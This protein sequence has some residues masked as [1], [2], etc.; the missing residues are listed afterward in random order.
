MQVRVVWGSS[1]DKQYLNNNNNSTTTGYTVIAIATMQNKRMFS[2]RSALIALVV[3][4]LHLTHGA[5]PSSGSN[6][7][8]V[9]AAVEGLGVP[10][11]PAKGEFI[12]K[13]RLSQAMSSSSHIPHHQMPREGGGVGSHSVVDSWNSPD[14][15]LSLGW[16]LIVDRCLAHT[17]K[18]T[19]LTMDGC[20]F[21]DTSRRH[22][23][24]C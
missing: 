2:W 11:S 14:S 4:F 19:V 16:P 12:D 21:E 13:Y 20:A 17:Q 10:K 22:I 15:R 3:V 18:D 9:L 5:P 7:S 1:P 24:S 6:C 23:Y 8:S